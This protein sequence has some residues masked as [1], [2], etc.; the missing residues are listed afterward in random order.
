[1]TRIIAGAARGISLTVPSSGTR[2][3][4]DRVRESLFA[5]L[6]SIDAIR[7]ARVLDLYAGSGAL[8]IECAS[9][10]AKSVDLV[11]KSGQAAKIAATNAAKVA[12]AGAVLARAHALAV[13]TYLKTAHEPWDLVF[14]DPPYDLGEHEL[15]TALTLLA[16]RLSEDAIVIVE[17]D[18]RSPA[19][20][21]DEAELADMRSKTYGDTTMWWGQPA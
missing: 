18:K 14:L 4:S 20:A 16:P 19:P 8:G 11:E 21:W 13:S 2:P 1:M 10:G 6:E 3:T 12:K 15:T 17:R 5:S 7:D 9:R